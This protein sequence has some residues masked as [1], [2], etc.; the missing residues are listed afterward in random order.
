M[1]YVYLRIIALIAV[2]GVHVY[3]S[4]ATNKI[5]AAFSIFMYHF[6]AMGV[7]LFFLISGYFAMNRKILDMREYYKKRAIRIIIPF[8]I[9]SIIYTVFLT[10]F[11]KHDLVGILWGEN[12]Y[13]T[14]IFTANVHGTY[15][16]VYA[17]MFF[18]FFAPFINKLVYSLKINEMRVLYWGCVVILVWMQIYLYMYSKYNV[19]SDLLTDYINIGG[20]WLLECVLLFLTG[21]Y[22]S[23]EKMHITCW[24][25]I[26]GIICGFILYCYD[27]PLM[28]YVILFFVA[29]KCDFNLHNGIFNR[30]LLFIDKQSYSVYL[31]HA[32]VLSFTLKITSFIEFLPMRLVACY[33]ITIIVSIF[34]SYVIDG[35]IINKIIKLAQ[36]K[37]KIN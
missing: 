5:N 35:V 12:S 26:I 27:V 15:W 31:I 28:Q 36:V 10:G 7:P 20:K 3:G 13:I 2:V 29:E 19:G 30:I 9:Y 24:L 1:Y 37:V 32:A 8:L 11:E 4:L 21:Y 25:K 18:F 14:R 33:L 16:Y 23:V 6:T 22:V 34:A 17:I